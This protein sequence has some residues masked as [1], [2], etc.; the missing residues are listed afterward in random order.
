MT[1]ETRRLIFRYGLSVDLVILGTAVAMLLRDPSALPLLMPSVFAAASGLSTWK[2]GW[3]SGLATTAL[4]LLSMG[5]L[6]HASVSSLMATL[7]A[8]LAVVAIV[9]TT[10]IAR[11]GRAADV[12]PARA[13]PA[14][15]LAVPAPLPEVPAAPSRR[16]ATA[17]APEARMETPLEIQ[18][19]RPDPAGRS[20]DQLL[21]D[22]EP[23][24]PAPISGRPPAEHPLTTAAP[25]ADTA[26]LPGA[27][28]GPVSLNAGPQVRRHDTG[29]KE[30]SRPSPGWSPVRWL[31]SIAARFSARSEES[32]GRGGTLEPS[33][34]RGRKARLLLIEK[35][36]AAAAHLL[37]LL[38]QRGV[39][40]EIVERWIEASARIASFRPDA[41]LIDT[42][43]A[44]FL[45]IHELLAAQAGSTPLFL[46]S[47]RDA[48][49]PALRHNGIV[50]R[51]YDPDEL[52]RVG[53]HARHEAEKARTKSGRTRGVNPPEGGRT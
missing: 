23:D 2:G 49:V 25:L 8:S 43:L 12:Q 35:R 52:V 19:A 47:K 9:R 7:L 28:E 26:K 4:S 17:K 44:D 53:R 11:R 22:R 20:A 31:R 48:S 10:G 13:M 15:P 14:I 27:P 51:P 24:V 38:R 36:Q 21:L 30:S 41:I 45:K 32:K 40:I 33:R 16:E 6:L 39:E 29:W 18:L 50:L 42:E 3:Q 1:A 37:P 46:T 34:R 5:W